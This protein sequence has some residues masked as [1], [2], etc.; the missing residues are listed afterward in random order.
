M[1][2]R[3]SIG[4]WIALGHF[5][6][7]AITEKVGFDLLDVDMEHSVIDYYGEEHFN[8]T[9]DS[10]NCVPY[11]RAG[12]NDHIIINRVLGAVV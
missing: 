2:N 1:R 7:A 6:V 10:N 12:A 4:S 9:I 5:L 8:A 11:V 3:I